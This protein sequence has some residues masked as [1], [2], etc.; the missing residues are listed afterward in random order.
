[1]DDRTNSNSIAILLGITISGGA[2]HIWRLDFF[3]SLQGDALEERNLTAVVLDR[4]DLVPPDQ[5][6]LWTQIAVN[7]PEHQTVQ[8][9][10]WHTSLSGEAGP[11]HTMSSSTN[12]SQW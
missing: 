4:Q 2:N 5:Q 7:V 6:L 1:L 9:S 10:T 8:P 3:R 12:W 11:I